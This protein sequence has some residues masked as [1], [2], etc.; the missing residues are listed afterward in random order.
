MNTGEVRIINGRLSL[1]TGGQ[2][3]GSHGISNFWHWRTIRKDGTLGKEYSGY[4]SG[5]HKFSRPINHKVVIKVELF[6]LLKVKQ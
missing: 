6:D 1:I 3:Y 5:E 4:N 2:M